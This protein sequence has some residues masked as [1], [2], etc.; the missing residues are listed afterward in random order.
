MIYTSR[1]GDTFFV[2]HPVLQQSE[3][4]EV[5]HP[6]LATFCYLCVALNAKLLLKT[7]PR[8]PLWL[9]HRLDLK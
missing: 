7:L 5:T 1:R 4:L 3:L 9:S 8:C 2:I 6:V